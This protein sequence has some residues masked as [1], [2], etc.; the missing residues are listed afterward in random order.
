MIGHL[1][2]QLKNSYPK[3]DPSKIY[4]YHDHDGDVVCVVLRFES[5]RLTKYG[6]IDK[7]SR[8]IS[9]DAN[10]SKYPNLGG[11]VCKRPLYNSPGILAD[12]LKT[13]FVVE[14]EKCS[15]VL[16]ALGFCATTSMSGANSAHATDWSPLSGRHVV[17]WGDNDDA[18]EKYVMAVVDQLCQLGHFPESVKKILPG[19]VSS[20]ISHDKLVGADAFDYIDARRRDGFADPQISKC[21][22]D[23]IDDHL[24][25]EKISLAPTGKPVGIKQIPYHRPEPMKLDISLIP[26]QVQEFAKVKSSLIDIS[27]EGFAASIYICLGSLIGSKLYVQ[28]T[29]DPG[30]RMPANLWGLI[31]SEPGTNKTA[32]IG[33]AQEYLADLNNKIE[34]NHK[35]QQEDDG[36]KKGRSGY[37]KAMVNGGSAMGLRRELTRSTNGLAIV[38]DEFVDFINVFTSEASRDSATM[39]LNG[40]EGGK[41]D[42]TTFKEGDI[43]IPSN[44]LS[45][46]G[47]IQFDIIDHAMAIYREKKGGN[48]GFFARFQ[49]SACPQRV[50]SKRSEL[51]DGRTIEKVNRDFRDLLDRVQN[52][53]VSVFSC[54]YVGSQRE[55]IRVIKFDDEAQKLWDLWDQCRI[56]RENLLLA[57]DGDYVATIAMSSKSKS[58]KLLRIAMINQD[59]R[60]QWR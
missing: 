25:C 56:E 29:H 22:R 57:S 34:A 7:T 2:N 59:M 6:K 12:S 13:V 19:V 51:P 32:T 33:P 9:V 24:F 44:T 39:I 60:F 11:I 17:I 47:G 3:I 38:V 37:P 43:T 49:V 48:D 42:Y 53:D 40:W 18:G 27:P 5:N 20:A 23:A 26:D 58:V 8:P 4:R 50:V 52:L 36:E 41:P 21:I 16:I 14:G 30:W 55:P 54:D 10:G 1:Q 35:R 15:D 28:P 31:A 45:I 46:F